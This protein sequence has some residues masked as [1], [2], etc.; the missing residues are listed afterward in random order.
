MEKN[1]IILARNLWSVAVISKEFGSLGMITR[2]SG[3]E[4]RE[5]GGREEL[6][7]RKSFI[8]EDISLSVPILFRED[9][10]AE[11]SNISIHKLSLPPGSWMNRWRSRYS[12]PQHQSWKILLLLQVTY[13]VQSH[14]WVQSFSQQWYSSTPQEKQP[15]SLHWLL[16]S[17]FRRGCLNFAHGSNNSSIFAGYLHFG[18]RLKLA[19]QV[20]WSYSNVM[21]GI[22]TS[23]KK[24]WPSASS[25]LWMGWRTGN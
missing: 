19:L 25:F 17:I 4:Q 11:L 9:E 1:V 14:D 13:L 6:D 8:L 7:N 12:G 21:G 2:E 3:G 5:A 23:R 20:L 16:V 15:V 18:N 10:N 22:N 24:N